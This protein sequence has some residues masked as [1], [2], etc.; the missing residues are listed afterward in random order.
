[1][2]CLYYFD[3]VTWQPIAGS[4]GGG[5]GAPGPAGPPGPPG[6]DGESVEVFGPQNQTP[7]A[8]RKGDVWL[9]TNVVGTVHYAPFRYRTLGGK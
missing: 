2:A 8:I 7:T 9:S 1:M 5:G 6:D 4:G 3:G